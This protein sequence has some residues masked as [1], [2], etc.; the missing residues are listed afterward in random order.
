MDAGSA[1]LQD[2]VDE[3][4][5]EDCA[6]LVARILV[7]VVGERGQQVFGDLDAGEVLDAAQTGRVGGRQQAGHDRNGDAGAAGALDEGCVD[8]GVPEELRDREG[9]TGGLLD[10]EA[11]DLLRGR[12]SGRRIARGE[13][14]DGDRQGLEG[15]AQGLARVSVAAALFDGADQV[16]QFGGASDAAGS[17][18][19]VLLS[20][21]RVSAQCQ[22][23]AH[24]RLQV[25]VHGRDDLGRRVAHAGQVG[26]RLNRGVTHEALDR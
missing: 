16:D 21:R 2:G 11:F 22:E 18:L 17:G 13:G 26:D 6:E 10:E 8:L 3:A 15:G 19:P 1:R 23:G 4:R 20:H 25:V 14:G 5:A 7:G 24:A 9:G 12:G